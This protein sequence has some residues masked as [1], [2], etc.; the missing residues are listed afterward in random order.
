ML[1]FFPVT[2]TLFSP[3][4]RRSFFLLDCFLSPRFPFPP[5]PLPQ[6]TDEPVAP[7]ETVESMLRPFN[8][9]IPFTVQKGEI[10]GKA[11]SWGWGKGNVLGGT[12]E[13]RKEQQ[14]VLQFWQLPGSLTCTYFPFFFML[15]VS[16]L[17]FR[18]VRDHQQLVG[19]VGI[20]LLL[21]HP[22]CLAWGPFFG[23][24]V[25]VH[26]TGFTLGKICGA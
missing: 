22:T 17:W 19:E 18:P 4:V 20:C 16:S 24:R 15:H 26:V 12:W 7:P 1:P 11:G 25:K 6:A 14:A 2:S 23:R 21:S 13:G 3:S 5:P 10:T 8:L 9:V